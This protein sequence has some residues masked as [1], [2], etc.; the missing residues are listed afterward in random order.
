MTRL[1][2]PWIAYPLVGVMIAATFGARV[3]LNEI[4][5]N[6]SVGLLFTPTILVATLIGGFAP[7]LVAT[8][9]S[10]PLVYVLM[11]NAEEPL[12][13]AV[14]LA[15]FAAVGV[16][17]VWLGGSFRRSRMTAQDMAR[18]LHGREAHLQSI[19]DTAPDATV[20]IDTTGTIV[21]F[22]A[23]AVRQFGYQ[24]DEAVGRNVSMLMPSPYHEQHDSYL[25]HYLSTGEKRIIGLDRVVVGRRKDTSTFPMKLSVGEMQSEGKTYFTGFI[26]DLTEHEESQARLNEAQGE[27]ARLA[28]LNE[29]DE[30]AST[31]AHELNQPLSAITNYVQGCIKILDRIDVEEAAKMRGALSE[32][33]RQ[34]LHAGDVIRHLRTFAATGDTQRH[35]ADLKQ[36]IEDAGTLALV[37]ARERGIRTVFELGQGN[38][39]VMADSIQIQQVLINL[40]RNA[41]DAMHD[42]PDK[43]L[44]VSA[45]RAGDAIMEIQ[46]RDTGPG[47][48]DEIV[49]RLF[50]PFV[51]TKPKGMGIGLSISKRIVET[52]G[53]RI[54]ASRNDRG[55]TTFTFTLPIIEER[56]G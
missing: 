20:V 3:G 9:V 41:M 28:R 24:P 6:S 18:S 13:I 17:I 39:R 44:T 43:V 50:Q 51:T 35:P 54:E 14:G 36:L 10:L 8:A 55:G 37:G 12:A 56:A 33:A 4:L 21:T 11:V 23:A 49:A 25:A 52:H 7:G 53:G 2:E 5:P 1:Q 16:A 45:R 31:L 42:S 27:L 22:N 15:L 19:L 32:T 34:A 47:I 40:M 30:M 48:A 38:A 46:V 26:R 29:L